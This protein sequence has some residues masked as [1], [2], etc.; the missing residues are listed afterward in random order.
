MSQNSIDFFYSPNMYCG[1]LSP[2]EING[3]ILIDFHRAIYE[4]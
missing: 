1:T 4:I 3:K 2:L